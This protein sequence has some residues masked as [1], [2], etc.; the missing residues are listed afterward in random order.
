[1]LKQLR[2]ASWIQTRFARIV[3]NQVMILHTIISSWDTLNGG[4]M[5]NHPVEEELIVVEEIEAA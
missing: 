3:E 1:M 2:H 5:E 4:K